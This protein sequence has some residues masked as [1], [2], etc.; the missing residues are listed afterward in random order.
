MP[1]VVTCGGENRSGKPKITRRAKSLAK[2]RVIAKSC[3]IEHRGYWADVAHKGRVVA[4][5]IN[6]RKG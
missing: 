6:G 5:Y 1:I 4:S 3:S 2:A